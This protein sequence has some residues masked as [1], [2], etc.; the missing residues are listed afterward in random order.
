MPE[1]AVAVAEFARVLRPGGTAAA[2]VW[3]YAGE[4]QMLRHFFDAAA[5]LDPNGRELDEGRRFPMCRPEPLAEMWR[6]A[7]MR[8][9]SVRAID[10]PTVFADFDDYWTPFLGGQGAAPVLRD[11]AERG[12][13]GRHVRERIRSTLPVATDGTIRLDCACVG[14]QRV[15]GIAVLVTSASYADAARSQWRLRPAGSAAD[16]AGG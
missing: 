7:G 2:Y 13:N 12:V 9:V 11:V 4:M 15:S 16:V 5:S 10:V 1:P 6:S 14:R 3:D 8:D